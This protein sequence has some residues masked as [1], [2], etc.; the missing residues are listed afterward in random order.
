MPWW[1]GI[2]QF[3]SF[4]NVALSC[5]SSIQ[6]FC[7]V[8]SVPIFCS[9]IVLVPSHPVVGMSS[10]ILLLLA[11]RIFSLFWNVLIG[12]YCLILSWHLFS[13][14]SF[15]STFWFISLNCI[16]C[17]N[18]C[19]AFS[20]LSNIFQRFS[21]VFLHFCLC[22]QSYFPSRFWISVCLL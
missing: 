11:G 15:A 10:C 19:V 18:C 1:P 16:V 5:C 2:F 13:L 21:S 9:K 20:F 3:G 7:S 12:L 6:L 4:L 8:L 14:I 22:F 17:F